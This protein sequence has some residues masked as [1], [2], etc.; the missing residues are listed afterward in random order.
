MSISFHGPKGSLDL[1]NGTATRILTAMGCTTDTCAGEMPLYKAFLGLEKA[2]QE[3]KG[4]DLELACYL[5]TILNE[6]NETGGDTL[7]WN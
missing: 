4:Q 3:L 6:I 2:K 1:N 5:E 7:E